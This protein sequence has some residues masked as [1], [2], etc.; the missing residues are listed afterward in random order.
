MTFWVTEPPVITAVKICGI[1]RQAD[2]R[3]VAQCGAHALGFIFY[4]RSPRYVTPEAAKALIEDLP[5][6]ET[7]APATGEIFTP[8]G[9]IV[10]VGVFVN[11]DM[12]KVKDIALF[13]GLDLIQLHGDE[14]PDYCARFSRERVIKALQLKTAD[15]LK[16]IEDYPVRAILV[17]ARDG[18]RYGGTGKTSNWEL[19]ALART[20]APLVLSGGLHSGNIREAL[21]AVRPHAV[22]VNSGVETAPGIKDHERIKA[23]MGLISTFE[24]KG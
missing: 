14:S 15:D 17:D 22:D 23:I 11:E 2:A 5:K 7:A 6:T 9:R 1:T 19:A 13:C 16:R 4:T 10:T 24:W 21:E 3:F 12:E 20:R 18:E 8:R